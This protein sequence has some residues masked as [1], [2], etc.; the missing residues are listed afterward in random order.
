MELS[1]GQLIKNRYEIICQIGKG[2][3]GNTYKAVD[4]LVNRFVAIKV[5]KQSLA[6]EAAILKALKDVPNISHLYDYFLH[7][8]VHYIVMRLVNGKSLSEYRDEQG[9]RLTVKQLV[10][11]L[12]SVFITLDQMHDNGIIHRDIS[13]GNLMLTEDNILYLIDFGTATSLSEGK[14]R[15]HLSFRHKGLESPEHSDISRQGPWTDIYSLCSTIVYLLTGEGVQ[16]P[17]DRMVF[18]PVPQLLTGVSLS[19]KMQ[20]ALI[21]GLSVDPKHRYEK[22]SSFAK[23][24]M[25]IERQKAEI[26]N[27]SVHYHAKTHIGCRDTNQDNFI[28]D[29]LYAYTGDDCEIKGYIDCDSD[30]YHIVAIADGVASAMHAE[31][32]SKAAIQAVAH[33]LDYYRYSETLAENLM[34]ELLDQINEKILI[35]GKKIGKTATTLTLLLWKN[36][37]YCM[38]NIGDS[39][40]FILSGREL[41]QLSEEHTVAR[42]RIEAGKSVKK[43]DF[44][45]LSRYLGKKDVAGSQMA[46]IRTGRIQKGDIFFLCSDGVSKALSQGQKVRYLKSD[47]DLAIKKMFAKCL[48]NPKMDNCTAVI[49][50][51]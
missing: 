42:D 39:P 51:F 9:G 12:P 11:M 10:K 3:F 1:K 47:G 22:V 34:E 46:H 45:L 5:S 19:A 31:L 13:P 25:G 27:Y 36:D 7:D 41:T 20:N 49:L 24:F 23:S 50:K 18:D 33:F 29:T 48:K 21:K 37:S 43:E 17:E 26:S 28:V 14:L 4:H 32:A 6:Q 44:H 40:L 38:A 16:Q 2:G 15:N 8:K 30:E 35:L